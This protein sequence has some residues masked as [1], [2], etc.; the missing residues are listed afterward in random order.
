DHGRCVVC[1]RAK[2]VETGIRLRP[3]ESS[4]VRLASIAI[5]YL[6]VVGWLTWPLGAQLRSALGAANDTTR[7]DALYATWALAHESW[8]LASAPTELANGNIYHPAP[9]ALF[10]GPTAF[11]ALP[12][13]APVF[14]ATDNPTLAT[15]VLFLGAV[16]LTG[17]T[18]H[19][20]AARW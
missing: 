6:L 1:P 9:H 3:I 10:Y 18:I 11:G 4:A 16:A 12:L 19:A 5:F 8:S 20:V 17:V 2:R 7:Y 13:F 15:N 14:L